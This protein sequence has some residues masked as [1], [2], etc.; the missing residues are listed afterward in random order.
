MIIGRKEL[1]VIFGCGF[2]HDLDLTWFSSTP[3]PVLVPEGI[4]VPIS[5]Q[6][7]KIENP[8]PTGTRVTSLLG[9][10]SRWQKRFFGKRDQ[11]DIK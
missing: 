9:T 5:D 3:F 7:A 6:F 8:I 2:G 11:E 1:I 4:H 10:T